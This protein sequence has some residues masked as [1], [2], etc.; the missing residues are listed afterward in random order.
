LR[1]WGLDRLAALTL[2]AIFE[3]GAVSWSDR[4]LSIAQD[5][6]VT[7]GLGEAEARQ[8]LRSLSQGGYIEMTAGF[9]GGVL[10][11]KGL[12]LAGSLRRV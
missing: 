10:T 3:S 7:L 11:R 12:R 9:E 1:G 2:G 8:A 6:A 4:L 5:V